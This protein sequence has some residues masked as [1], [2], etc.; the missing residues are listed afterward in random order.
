MFCLIYYIVS[1]WD[2]TYSNTEWIVQ[3]QSPTDS[4]VA[5][6]FKPEYYKETEEADN[7]FFVRQILKVVRVIEDKCFQNAQ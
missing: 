2:I 4:F 5:E 3:L 6:K 7:L 1:N